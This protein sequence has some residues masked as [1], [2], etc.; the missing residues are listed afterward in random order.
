MYNKRACIQVHTRKQTHSHTH[1]PNYRFLQQP[2]FSLPQHLSSLVSQIHQEKHSSVMARLC[3]HTK[4]GCILTRRRLLPL[5]SALI[6]QSKACV[7]PLRRGEHQKQGLKPA[8]SCVI[9]DHAARWEALWLGFGGFNSKN[10]PF[11]ESTRWDKHPLQRCRFKSRL[12]PL[13]L[14]LV[15]PGLSAVSNEA[16][17]WQK[18]I[19]GQK[20]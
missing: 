6:F 13:H 20:T 19:G 10:P 8:L 14:S 1:T 17:M 5:Q 15:F 18:S 3:F 9:L 4:L 12:C 16:Q 7:V 2:Q 11:W